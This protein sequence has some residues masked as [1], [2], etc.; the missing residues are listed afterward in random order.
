[1]MIDWNGDV[2]L[3]VQDW[4]KR[5]KFSNLNS[6]SLK[7]CWMSNGIRIYRSLLGK[8]KRKLPPCNNCD[9]DGKLHGFNHI[10]Q[11]DKKT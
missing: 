8:G 5:V 7:E 4:N 6:S 2:L 3:C 9:V 11:W 1:M 10:R